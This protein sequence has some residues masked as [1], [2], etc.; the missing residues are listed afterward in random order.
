VLWHVIWISCITGNETIPDVQLRDL[1]Y[2]CLMF[3]MCLGK[4]EEVGL[5][6]RFEVVIFQ[7]CLKDLSL[8]VYDVISFGGYQRLRA[9][10]YL[11]IRGLSSQLQSTVPFQTMIQEEIKRRLKSGNTCYHSVQNLL[12]FSFL[13]KNIKHN[14]MLNDLYSSQNIIRMIRSRWMRWAEHVVRVG[15]WRG[16]YRVL[17]GKPEGKGPLG[18]T[19]DIW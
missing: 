19:R 5:S 13:S 6:W 14:D 11:H 1:E 7:Y 12:S 16:A 2:W 4:E 17:V 9:A 3:I 15:Q 10:C 18:R 8:Q